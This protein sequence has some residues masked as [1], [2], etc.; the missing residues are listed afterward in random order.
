M[1]LYSSLNFGH[2][3][4]IGHI[5]CL[6]FRLA[7]QNKFN[8]LGDKNKTLSII[9]KTRLQIEEKNKRIHQSGTIFRG[10]KNLTLKC[11]LVCC[12]S[13]IYLLVRFNHLTVNG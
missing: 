9:V 8:I 1:A 2:T 13:Y 5:E 12:L 7:L 3:L 6:K 10:P 4:H 11:N